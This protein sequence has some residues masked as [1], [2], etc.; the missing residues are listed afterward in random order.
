MKV[1]LIPLDSDAEAFRLSLQNCLDRL[2]SG[3]DYEIEGSI[4]SRIGTI[5]CARSLHH[6]VRI[7]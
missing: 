5:W 4:L 7:N 3:A 6:G 1:E 2:Q